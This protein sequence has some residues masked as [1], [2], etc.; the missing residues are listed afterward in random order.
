MKCGPVSRTGR[1]GR[2]T[3][4][5]GGRLLWA[6][7][8]AGTSRSPNGRE[9]K[10][11]AVSAGP[12]PRPRRAGGPRHRPSGRHRLPDRRAEGAPPDPH[13]RVRAAA[14]GRLPRA[15]GPGPGQEG[16]AWAILP[17]TTY[18]NPT[19]ADGRGM[20]RR[21]PQNVVREVVAVADA[22]QII[23]TLTSSIV[24]SDCPLLSLKFR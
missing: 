19:A 7:S 10:R 12:W 20:R 13:R 6:P 9:P 3:P 5:R 16:A 21:T 17:I 18:V 11:G 15:R 8:G 14:D 2:S 22:R 4:A 24:D 23:T 1:A